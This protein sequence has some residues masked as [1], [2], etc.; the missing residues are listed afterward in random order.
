MAEYRQNANYNEI[1]NEESGTPEKGARGNTGLPF[2][3]CKK[4][5]I[6]LPENATPREAWDRNP[7]EAID[8]FRAH[9][10][11]NK[12]QREITS[13]TYERTQKRL[14]KAVEAFIGNG[15]S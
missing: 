6:S 1:I 8:Y 3:L 14:N 13:S 2:G 11:P 12:P 4:Y 5:G 9:Y 10:D 7:Q 15:L